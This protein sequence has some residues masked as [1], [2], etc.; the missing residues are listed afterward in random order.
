MGD[1]GLI[2]GLE[3]VPGDGHAPVFLLGESPW[4]EVPGGIPS[5]GLQKVRHDCVTKHYTA[6]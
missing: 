2:P 6:L 1:L 4:T 5:M 3:R